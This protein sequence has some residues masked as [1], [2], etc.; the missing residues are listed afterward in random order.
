MADLEKTAADF[1][2]TGVHALLFDPRTPDN[3]TDSGAADLDTFIKLQSAVNCP[4]II[5]GGITAANVAEIILKTTPQTIDLMTGVES[6]PGIKD[7]TKVISFFKALQ[8]TDH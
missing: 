5:A 8:A 3:A 2:A 6:R 4:V 1:C 7:E